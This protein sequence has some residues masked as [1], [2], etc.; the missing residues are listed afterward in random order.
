MSFQAEI[1]KVNQG[2]IAPVYLVLGE[3][4]ALQERFKH[5]LEHATLQGEDDELNKIAID[6]NET[7][8][9]DGLLEAESIPFFGDR[10]VIFLENPT[11]LTG[12]PAT[13]G[14]DHDIDQLL[15]YLKQPV[16][17]SVVVFMA[18]YPKLD[19]RKKVVK[20]LKKT[21]VL[22]DAAP[23]SAGELKKF[24]QQAFLEANVSIEAE[25]YETLL[26]RTNFD[27]SK[28]E[29]EIQKLTI[30]AET[31]GRLTTKDID[32][33]VPRTLQEDVFKLAEFILAHN[34]E[35]ALQLLDDLLL[36]GEEVLKL[37][38]ILISQFR[39][40]LQVKILLE[41]RFAQAQ[42][43]SALKVHP[44]RV[45]HGIEAVRN[46]PLT[47]LAQLQNDLV[48]QD[49]SLKQSVMD[50]KLMLQLFIL[51]NTQK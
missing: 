51:K 32:A 45:K 25:A 13:N 35:Q 44:F 2:E 19:E 47:R 31:K 37:N 1:K 49:F 4:F 41:K 16:D 33:L 26:Q 11:F 20:Q 22:I 3:E 9:S 21:A 43:A 50:Q 36:R 12:S 14:P 27:L 38:G 46:L 18:P 23:I 7:P 30:Y 17:T 29:N 6:L 48:Q 5:A 10:R 28:L 39:L 40:N 34:S 8:L 15:A 24:G 42:I